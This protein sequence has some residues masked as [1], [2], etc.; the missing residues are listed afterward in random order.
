MKIN[1]MN[2]KAFSIRPGGGF[3]GRLKR[4]AICWKEK[5]NKFNALCLEERTINFELCTLHLER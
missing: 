5:R 2:W 3:P 4:F 1:S